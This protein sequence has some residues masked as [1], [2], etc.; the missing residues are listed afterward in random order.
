MSSSN[1]AQAVL[2]QTSKLL[3][4][5]AHNNCPLGFIFFRNLLLHFNLAQEPTRTFTIRSYCSHIEEIEVAKVLLQ[6]FC[7][8]GDLV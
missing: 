1:V 3:N 7:L 4:A 8:N 5:Q 6:V 2:A